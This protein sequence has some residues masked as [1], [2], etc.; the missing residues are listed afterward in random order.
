M[1]FFKSNGNCCQM[2]GLAMGAFLA[3][4]LLANISMQLFEG[5]IQDK[6]KGI[7]KE[8]TV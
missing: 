6:N 1:F 3:V 5:V 7:M 8:K 2:D 4:I